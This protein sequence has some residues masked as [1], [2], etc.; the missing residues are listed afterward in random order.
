MLACSSVLLLAPDG[1]TASNASPVPSLTSRRGP[2]T[3]ST[4]AARGLGWRRMGANAQILPIVGDPIGPVCG[5]AACNQSIVQVTQGH[6]VPRTMVRSH[7]ADP[8]PLPMDADTCPYVD[9]NHDCCRA[10]FSLDRLDHLMRTCFGDFTSCPNH[11]RLRSLEESD[12]SSVPVI[13]TLRRH[14]VHE[15]L[16]PTGS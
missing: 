10:R 15:Q 8:L 5:H 3:P 12:E 1:L 11:W 13:I 16:R 14:L 4:V 9:G 7:H 2:G 6:G